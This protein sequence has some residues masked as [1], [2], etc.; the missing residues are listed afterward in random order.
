MSDKN[1]SDDHFRLLE[2]LAPSVIVADIFVTQVFPK[3]ARIVGT[4]VMM[5]SFNKYLTKGLDLA[6]GTCTTCHKASAEVEDLCRPCWNEF[7]KWLDDVDPN[8]VDDVTD[9]RL[10]QVRRQMAE[11]YG[12][13]MTPEETRYH[14]H[15][16][17]NRI[18]YALEIQGER[19]PE[20]DTEMWNMLRTLFKGRV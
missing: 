16:A 1:T 3:M 18:R 8:G 19:C 7:Q 17:C 9:D 20:S 10:I 5:D 14:Q 12:K 2:S 13:E 11:R 6:S 4:E 15:Q